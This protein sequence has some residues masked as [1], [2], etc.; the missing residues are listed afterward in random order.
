MTAKRFGY[1][2]VIL[3]LL[4]FALLKAFDGIGYLIMLFLSR[5]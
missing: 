4:M 5:G 3:S 2:M 1:N